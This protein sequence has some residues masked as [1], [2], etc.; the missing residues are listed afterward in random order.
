[1]RELTSGNP[2]IIFM[3]PE[4]GSQYVNM[5]KNLYDDEIVFK[6][7][8]D[9]CCKILQ[10]HLGL[11]LRTI[12][13]PKDS[14]R[15]KA[16]KLLRET[17][18]TQPALFTIGYA[19][20]KLWMSWGIQPKG[21]IGHSIGEFAGA[22][23]A[24]VF[25]LEDALMLVAN[26]G[27]MMQDLPHGS[28]LSVRL[29]AAEVEKEIDASCS[30]AAINGPALCVVAGPTDKIEKLQKEFE[31]REVTAKQIGRASCRERV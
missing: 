13:Y 26:R 22:H 27:K 9:T 7:A 11:D 16:E 21:F 4:Q 30:I 18:Y 20:A 28:M 5:G 19:L 6:D 25:S 1:S 24:G 23:L 15:E 29:P 2:E 3:F 12:L 31:K 8:V 10:L 17:V 14:E